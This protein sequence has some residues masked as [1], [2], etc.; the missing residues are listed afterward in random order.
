VGTAW[1]T[2]VVGRVFYVNGTAVAPPVPGTARIIATD[3]TASSQWPYAVLLENGD[4]Y[5]GTGSRWDYYG[6][7]L[8]S[9]TGADRSTW[10][11]LKARYR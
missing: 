6:N 11:S 5:Y 4:F 9:A 1:F 10:G 8:G 2:G 7:L 3:G